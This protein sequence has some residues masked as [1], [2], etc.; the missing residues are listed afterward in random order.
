MGRALALAAVLA[1]APAPRPPLPEIPD[2]DALEVRL[3]RADRVVAYARGRFGYRPTNPKLLAP[4]R[5]KSRQS[6]QGAAPP[7]NW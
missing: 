6:F 7:P 4:A 1:C 2:L 5:P 3:H